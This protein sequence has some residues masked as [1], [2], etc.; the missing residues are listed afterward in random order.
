MFT[1]PNYSVLEEL[2][3]WYLI[4][5]ITLFFADISIDILELFSG[6]IFSSNIYLG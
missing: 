1:E 2:A 3:G 5:Q 4:F 6:W